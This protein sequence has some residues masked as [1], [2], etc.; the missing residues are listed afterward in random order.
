MSGP[1]DDR[2]VG[3]FDR[4]LMRRLLAFAGPHRRAFIIALILA[5]AAAGCDVLLPVM[6]KSAIDG[7]LMAGDHGHLLRIA[8]CVAMILI[9][10]YAASAVGAWVTQDATQRVLAEIRSRV[11]S[12]LMRAALPWLERQPIGRLMTRATGDVAA[13]GDMYAT[14]LVGAVRDCCLLI[15]V[16]TVLLVVDPR[17]G[18]IAALALPPL[19]WVSWQFRLRA[20]DAFREVRT[21]IAAVLAWL[22][23]RLSGGRTLRLFARETDSARDFAQVNGDEYRANMRQLG[24]FAMFQPLIQLIAGVAAATLLWQGGLGVLAGGLTLG[25]LNLFLLSLDLMLSPARDLA[26]RYAQLQGALAAAERIASVLDLPA[27]PSGDQR[28]G[29]VAGAIAFEDVWF[30][31]RGDDTPTDADWVLRGVS[32]AARAGTRLALVGPTGAG[33]TTIA[34]LALGFLRPTRGRV[35][36]DGHDLTSLDLSWLRAR[37]GAVFQESFLFAGSVAENIGLRTDLPRARMDQALVAAQL[38]QAIAALPGGLDAPL[39]GGGALSAG[40]RQ[41]LALA[42]ALACDP[43]LIVLDEAT[44]HVD[45][46]TESR[47]RRAQAALSAGRTALIIAHRLATI[48]DADAILVLEHGRIA[49]QGPH[50]DLYAR[51][52]LYRELH[53]RQ[54]A[55]DELADLDRA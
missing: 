36:I 6:T 4:G 26:E 13:I 31:Y 28:P 21:R 16:L 51:G 55:L 1:D 19:A 14:V 32:F 46:A 41:L 49:D 50:A 22:Q 25:E 48:R 7:G 53:D 54:S 15:G 52:G 10:R 27:E 11:C 24:L 30:A 43:R 45:V 44:A 40:E 47:I 3:R 5:M 38:D 18:V 35:L 8:V 23:E 9:A 33:K 20:R 37:V 34:L 39:T 17:L 12:H 42:R 2:L 29:T